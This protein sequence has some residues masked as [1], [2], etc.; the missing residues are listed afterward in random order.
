SFHHLT[1][2]LEELGYAVRC[3]DIWE[4]AEHRAVELR[5]RDG[6]T[7]R[8]Y[9]VDNFDL[10]R[11]PW[12]YPDNE[13]DAVV[14]CEVLEHLNTDPV[15]VLSEINRVLK[16]DGLLLLTTPNIASAKGLSYLLRGESP[17]VFGAFVPEGLP[18]DRHNREYT[19]C[20]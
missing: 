2:A 14:F 16:K 19:P 13:F 15:M 9:T 3:T 20:E 5:S 1:P 18:T 17:Y 12:P 6:N 10:Q 11:A 4:G 7:S 8:S